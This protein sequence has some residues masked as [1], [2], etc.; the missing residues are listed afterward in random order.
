MVYVLYVLGMHMALDFQQ[1][2]IGLW[3]AMGIC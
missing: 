3:C 1:V 2:N